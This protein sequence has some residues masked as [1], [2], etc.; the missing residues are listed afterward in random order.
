MSRFCNVS[1]TTFGSAFDGY[2]E[3]LRSIPLTVDV[4]QRNASPG[5]QKAFEEWKSAIADLDKRVAESGNRNIEALRD[6]V[7]FAAGTILRL[8]ARTK[9]DAAIQLEVIAHGLRDYGSN[10]P[11]AGTA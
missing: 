9:T 11:G 10:E 5:F 1:P 7:D 4:T 6:R 8:D 3:V 2:T